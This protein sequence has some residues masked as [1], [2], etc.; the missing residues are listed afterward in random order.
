MLCSPFIIHAQCQTVEPTLPTAKFD[1]VVTCGQDSIPASSASPSIST[2]GVV[3]IVNDT[4]TKED[5]EV[6]MTN[7]TDS[8]LKLHKK[9]SM[10]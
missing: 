6:V 5:V 3:V 7:K 10:L 9:H 2:S 1:M 4:H 8:K